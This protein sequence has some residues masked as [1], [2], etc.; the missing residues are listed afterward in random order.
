MAAGCMG[1]AEAVGR[2]LAADVGG[3]ANVDCVF[4]GRQVKAAIVGC[5]RFPLVRCWQSI[6]DGRL[7]RN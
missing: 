4:P 2:S 6:D 7:G 3:V 1:R 5:G